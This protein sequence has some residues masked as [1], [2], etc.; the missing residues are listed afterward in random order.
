MYFCITEPTHGE[1]CFFD[2]CIGSV[3]Q[4]DDPIHLYIII[5][6]AVSAFN[7]LAISLWNIKLCRQTL[8]RTQRIPWMRIINISFSILTSIFAAI[9]LFFFLGKPLAIAAA[10]HNLCEWAFVIYAIY[11]NKNQRTIAFLISVLW[12][13]VVICTVITIDTFPKYLL[14]EQITGAAMDVVLTIV[15]YILH[16]Q[17]RNHKSNIPKNIFLKPYRA[18][19]IHLLFTIFPLIISNFT[20]GQNFYLSFVLEISIY[21]SVFFTHYWYTQFVS[22][23]EQYIDIPNVHNDNC[24][25]QHP[26]TINYCG[27]RTQIRFYPTTRLLFWYIISML[28]AL[29]PTVITPKVIM[30]INNGKYCDSHINC[31][32][33]SFVIGTSVADVH[34]GMDK[35]FEYRISSLNLVNKARAYPGNKFYYFTKSLSQN[36]TFVSYLFHESWESIEAAQNWIHYARNHIFDNYTYSMMKDHYFTKIAGYKPVSSN[37][38]CDDNK[39]IG[40]GSLR[41]IF[42][43]WNRC[44]DLWNH[45]TNFENCEWILGCNHTEILD[46]FSSERMLFM[47]Y[48][49]YETLHYIKNYENVKYDGPESI[50]YNYSMSITE[51]N[52]SLQI[53]LSYNKHMYG[54][55]KCVGVFTFYTDIN[56]A[57][58]DEIYQS[59]MKN[60]VP[61]LQQKYQQE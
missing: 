41:H 25:L 20:I 1:Q 12:I 13:A 22:D 61:F 43:K 48:G 37:V 55:K 49:L 28:I 39:H 45:I 47:K 33:V 29:V 56:I 21:I 32:T 8:R 26:K 4:F 27:N 24:I 16:Q 52:R 46:Q 11:P 54:K 6:H 40:I 23:Y 18:H 35:A 14:F 34:I 51:L 15:W 3:S 17:N 58:V 60:N 10:L 7:L 44:T 36:G 5:G 53:I 19:L 50:Q 42:T 30:H 31:H 2:L 57:T 9:R 38:N 59:F